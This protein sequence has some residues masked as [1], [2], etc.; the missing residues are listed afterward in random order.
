MKSFSLDESVNVQ[1]LT[2]LFLLESFVFVGLYLLGKEGGRQEARV[3]ASCQ[4][5][6]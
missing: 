6:K 5:I 2:L 3:A 1:N 4:K